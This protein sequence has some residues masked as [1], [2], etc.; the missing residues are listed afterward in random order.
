MC[1]PKS[2]YSCWVL[3]ILWFFHWIT[4]AKKLCDLY[5]HL[6]VETGCRLILI[7][8]HLNSGFRLITRGLYYKNM[9]I[10]KSTC[11]EVGLFLLW[12]N[13]LVSFTLANNYSNS[14]TNLSEHDETWPEFSTQGVDVLVYAMQLHSYQK[15]QLE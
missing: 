8:V 11:L 2:S 9:M 5:C 13:K 3:A 7:M 14:C 15:T 12:L 1:P 4:V 6:V 10:I